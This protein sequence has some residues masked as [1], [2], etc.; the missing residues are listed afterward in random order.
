MYPGNVNCYFSAIF[1]FLAVVVW[2]SRSYLGNGELLN[3]PYYCA[4]TSFLTSLVVAICL[5]KEL[6]RP[7]GDREINKGPLL[8]V[9]TRQVDQSYDSDGGYSWKP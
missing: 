9:T 1:T 5:Y 8:L 6:Q 7:L 4:I 3:W 2:A